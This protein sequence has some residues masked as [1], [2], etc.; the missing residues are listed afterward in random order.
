MQQV[1][2]EIKSEVFERSY[3]FVEQENGNS[4]HCRTA[5]S[6]MTEQKKAEEVLQKAHEELEQRVLKWT[7][8]LR[9]ANKK[10][11]KRNQGTPKDSE[12]VKLVA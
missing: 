12:D 4:S 6:D 2:L 5:I 1:A 10:T 7:V 11:T 3:Q 9:K 8:D